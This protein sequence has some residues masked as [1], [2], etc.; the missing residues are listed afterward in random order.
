MDKHR[1]KVTVCD[2]Y[3]LHTPSPHCAMH[4]PSTRACAG[5]TVST[6]IYKHELLQFFLSSNSTWSC[7]L[8]LYVGLNGE[9]GK[10]GYRRKLSNLTPSAYHISAQ[11]RFLIPATAAPPVGNTG[12][13]SLT[14]SDIGAQLSRA[15]KNQR[16]AEQSQTG[17]DTKT[18]T[19]AVRIR[20]TIPPPPTHAI[21]SKQGIKRDWSFCLP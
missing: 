9:T 14:C 18:E 10:R 16:G 19:G 20:A 4:A 1:N 12:R 11:V 21:T 3:S 2:P 17:S 8:L 15:P 13:K 6:R 5:V 7:I